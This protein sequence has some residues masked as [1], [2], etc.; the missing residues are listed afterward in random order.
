MKKESVKVSPAQIELLELLSHKEAEDHFESLK[1][2]HY[3]ATY[4]VDNGMVELWASRSVHDLMDALQK[5]AMENALGKKN[6][7]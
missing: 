1:M 3:L 7:V 2:V 6:K 5:I 4:V